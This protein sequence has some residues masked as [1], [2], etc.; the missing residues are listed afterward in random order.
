[1]NGVVELAY[2]LHIA[3]TDRWSDSENDPIS[4]EELQEY[5]RKKGDFEYSESI[6]STGPV[7]ISMSGD[8]F[9]WNNGK[10]K[11]PF[12][13]RKGRLD[14]SRPDDEILDKMVEIAADLKAKVQG[15]EGEYY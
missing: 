1:M 15:D 12:Q 10:C 8:F 2:D 14:V 5:F 4:M 13:F 7:T 3:R 6:S 9:I 11:V